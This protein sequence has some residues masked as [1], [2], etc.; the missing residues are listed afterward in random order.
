MQNCFVFCRFSR[1]DE[2]VYVMIFLVQAFWRA[3]TIELLPDLYDCKV[4]YGS[5]PNHFLA[6]FFLGALVLGLEVVLHK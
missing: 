4:F 1:F 5:G 2:A 3:G 6:F